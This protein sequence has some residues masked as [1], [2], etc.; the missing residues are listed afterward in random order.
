MT[1]W[2]LLF[3]SE[4]Q[5]RGAPDPYRAVLEAEGWAVGF[6]DLLSFSFR[7]LPQCRE[8]RL[9]PQSPVCGRLTAYD[10]AWIGHGPAGAP[11]SRARRHRAHQPACGMCAPRCAGRRCSSRR[12]PYLLRG[13][14]RAAPRSRGLW[15]TPPPSA[16]ARELSACVPERRILRPD[17]S[18]EDADAL[19]AQIVADWDARGHVLFLHGEP[20]L[21]T[22]PDRLRE[23][24]I[25]LRPLPVYCSNL[26]SCIRPPTPR[27][28]GTSAAPAWLVFFSPRG[29]EAVIHACHRAR[30]Q[31]TEAAS[32]GA[33]PEGR[34]PC[35]EPPR[36]EAPWVPAPTACRIA[37]IGATTSDAVRRLGWPVHAQSARPAAEE[38]AAALR[39]APPRP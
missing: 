28:A 10:A 5:R 36:W 29:A 27:G 18:K 23:A 35:E 22:L 25:P 32:A 12:Y 16:T 37:S 6:C 33:G 19:A 39:E 15:L 31:S 24:G 30:A 13:R 26:C 34:N 1:R 7:N 9:R 38:L 3:K 20:S 11:R 2:V 17:G 8:V 4:K 21:P 14:V